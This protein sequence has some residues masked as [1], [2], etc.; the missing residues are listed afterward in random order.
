MKIYLKRALEIYG[1]EYIRPSVMTLAKDYDKLP[2]LPK[3]TYNELYAMLHTLD[4]RSRM[5]NG[6]YQM[7]VHLNT[8]YEI[9]NP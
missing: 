8:R 9:D 2:I 7:L 4:N 1:N 5:A 3:I 6:I